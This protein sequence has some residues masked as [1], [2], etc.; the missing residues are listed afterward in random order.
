MTKTPLNCKSELS[1][2][3][4]SLFKKIDD[5][6]LSIIKNQMIT[7]ENFS[8]EK[9]D[10]A[11]IE[12]KK[13]LAASLLSTEDL[14][15]LNGD[16]DMFWHYLVLN[17]TIYRNFCKD[18][19]GKT[20]IDHVPVTSS[21]S[22]VKEP[23]KKTLKELEKYFGEPNLVHWPLDPENMPARWCAWCRSVLERKFPFESSNI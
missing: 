16:P 1:E 6:D 12:A 11:E 21:S 22:F 14:A 4:I 23:Y 7:N 20:F 10:E 8:Q 5:F 3:I 13:F 15:I 18:A 19:L 2:E 9:A 17:T